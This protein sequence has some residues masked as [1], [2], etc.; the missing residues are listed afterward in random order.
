MTIIVIATATA[1]ITDAEGCASVKDPSLR[2]WE[3]ERA[4]QGLL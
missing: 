4:V 1:T 2:A 3:S